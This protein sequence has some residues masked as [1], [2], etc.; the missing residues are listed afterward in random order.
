[1]KKIL[2]IILFLLVVTLMA[3]KSYRVKVINPRI[4]MKELDHINYY[5]YPITMTGI[6]YCNEDMEL[7]QHTSMHREGVMREGFQLRGHTNSV[8][9]RTI[10]IS[11]LHE[12]SDVP[13]STIHEKLMADELSGTNIPVI[14]TFVVD[15]PNAPFD[16]KKLYAKY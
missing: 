14:I 6:L 8:G 11:A 16:I 4:D 13:L 3:F 7:F 5:N 15:Q 2:K 1:M 10:S 12:G 9:L